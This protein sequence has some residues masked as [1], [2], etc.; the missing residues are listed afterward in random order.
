[1]IKEH[2]RWL[3]FQEEMSSGVRL[4]LLSPCLRALRTSPG[5]AAFRS[6]ASSQ[7]LACIL[8]SCPYF[9]LSNF[10]GCRAARSP[11]SDACLEPCNM[12]DDHRIKAVNGF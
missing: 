2:S 7:T 8:H 10:R 4:F 11:L 5:Y 1:M 3:Q 9:D 6:R 12:R